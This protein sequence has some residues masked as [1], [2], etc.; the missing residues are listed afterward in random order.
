M[1]VLGG[2]LG[3]VPAMLWFLLFL[4]AAQRPLFSPDTWTCGHADMHAPSR[5]KRGEGEV[6]ALRVQA[7]LKSHVLHMCPV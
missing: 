5:W 4:Q 7:D 3:R 1:I 6:T 2:F